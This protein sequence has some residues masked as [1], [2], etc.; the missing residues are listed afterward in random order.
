MSPSS[1]G[2]RLRETQTLVPSRRVQRTLSRDEPAYLSDQSDHGN[3][4][5]LSS[6]LVSPVSSSCWCDL[7]SVIHRQAGSSVFC[8][9]SLQY[10]TCCG[11]TSGLSP[12]RRLERTSRASNLTP[13]CTQPSFRLFFF[14]FFSF[15]SFSL[16]FMFILSAF[17]CR[18]LSLGHWKDAS[19]RF[20][21]EKSEFYIPPHLRRQSLSNVGASHLHLWFLLAQENG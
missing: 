16:N 6:R 9:Q 5:H 12:V 1:S 10:L 7:S 20:G 17:R 4:E 18:P 11:W 8:H 15:F 13:Q 14:F 3:A 19:V 21:S 2:R